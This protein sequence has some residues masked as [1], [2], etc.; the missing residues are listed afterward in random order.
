MS[1]QKRIKTRRKKPMNVFKFKGAVIAECGSQAAAAKMLKD[2]GCVNMNERR[3]SRLIHG[4]E[5][6][7]PEE[8]QMIFEKFGVRLKPAVEV[9]SR[10]RGVTATLADQSGTVVGLRGGRHQ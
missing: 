7:R 4:F 10:G 1:R 3:L 8:A 6:P 5:M 9:E 2:A